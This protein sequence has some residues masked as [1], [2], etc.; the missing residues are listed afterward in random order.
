VAQLYPRAL[1][2]LF[3]ASYDLQG[4]IGGI[5]TRLHT[6]PAPATTPV[7]FMKPRQHKA[8]M[9]K[10]NAVRTRVITKNA[11]FSSMKPALKHNSQCSLHRPE[12]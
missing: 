2:S 10:Q 11:D 5:V 8:P 4:Y 9:T 3:V 6:G 1:G 7:G 12:L